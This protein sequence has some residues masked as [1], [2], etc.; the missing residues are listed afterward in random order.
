MKIDAA[1]LKRWRANPVLF[2]EECLIDP[3]TKR[4]FVLLEA[5]KRFLEHAFQTDESALSRAA[6][7]LSEEIRQDHVRG[8]HCADDAAAVRRQLKL[9]VLRLKKISPVNR[10]L[11]LRIAALC[12]SSLRSASVA[13]LQKMHANSSSLAR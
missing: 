2:V 9:N 5:E 7:R 4:P 3:E 6:L 12:W 1:A 8:H 10:S 13:H 11:T